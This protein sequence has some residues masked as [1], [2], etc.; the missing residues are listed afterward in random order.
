MNLTFSEELKNLLVLIKFKDYNRYG[1]TLYA[2]YTHLKADC[3][4]PEFVW[5]FCKNPCF[6]KALIKHIIDQV[7]DCN[8]YLKEITNATKINVENIYDD[9]DDAT[10]MAFT[11]K[12]KIVYSTEFSCK[13]HAKTSFD[14]DDIDGEL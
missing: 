11:G 9:W 13:E 7:P 1:N 8:V 3:T 4:I 6:A 5:N 14:L 10:L 12:T 2:Q